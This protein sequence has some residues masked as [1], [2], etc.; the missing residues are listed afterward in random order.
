MEIYKIKYK[1]GEIHGK[2]EKE[3]YFIKLPN[4]YL[5]INVINGVVIEKFKDVIYETKVQML[6]K[7]GILE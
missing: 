1:A 6:N 2:K 7:E 3:G 4:G 5:E